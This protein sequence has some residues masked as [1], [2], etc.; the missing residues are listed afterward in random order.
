MITPTE[1]CFQGQCVATLSDSVIEWPRN[2]SI[3]KIADSISD[4]MAGYITMSIEYGKLVMGNDQTAL[5]AHVEQEESQYLDM[6]NSEEWT[7]IDSDGSIHHILAPIF[8]PENYLVW[9]FR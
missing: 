1:L 7:V 3:Y 8:H 2:D 6:I 4:R 9:M 5:K